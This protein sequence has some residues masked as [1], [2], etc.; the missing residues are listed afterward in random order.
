M[1]SDPIREVGWR[2]YTRND[3]LDAFRRRLASPEKPKHPAAK[4]PKKLPPLPPLP[5]REFVTEYMVK[6]ALTLDARS[7]T[8][9]KDAILSPLAQDWLALR[10]IRILRSEK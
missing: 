7:L 8:I 4:G 3:I 1:G 2:M 9:A 5:R 6:K 10:E